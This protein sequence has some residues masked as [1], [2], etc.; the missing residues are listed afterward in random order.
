MIE[1]LPRAVD[2]ANKVWPRPPITDR[3]SSSASSRKISHPHRDF[4]GKQQREDEPPSYPITPATSPQIAALVGIDEDA[5]IVAESAV[6]T[7]VAA[8]LASGCEIASN[9][10]AHPLQLQSKL[11]DTSPVPPCGIFTLHR[12]A[13]GQWSCDMAASSSHISSPSPTYAPYELLAAGDP[14][15]WTELWSCLRRLHVLC[16][17]GGSAHGSGEARLR[18]DVALHSMGMARGALPTLLRG[19]NYSNPDSSSNGG[20]HLGWSGASYSRSR[21]NSVNNGNVSR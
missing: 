2:A 1:G 19:K 11:L 13:Q 6:A 14:R 9:D 10:K 16:A 15:E 5:I 8:T 12:G 4:V 21:G 18:A 17:R 3:G 7:A 20:A